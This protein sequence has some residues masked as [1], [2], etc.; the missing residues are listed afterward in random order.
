MTSHFV[1]NKWVTYGN[2]E[3][4]IEEKGHHNCFKRFKLNRLNDLSEKEFCDFYF[5]HGSIHIYEIKNFK[6]IPIEDC[7]IDF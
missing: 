5:K 2:I 3:N 1:D 7:I 6:N 4:Y